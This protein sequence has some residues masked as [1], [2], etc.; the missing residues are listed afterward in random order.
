MG[1]LLPF[2]DGNTRFVSGIRQEIFARGSIAP[3]LPA[4]QYS[5]ATR[6]GVGE[7]S[8]ESPVLRKNSMRAENSAIPCGDGCPIQVIPSPSSAENLSRRNARGVYLYI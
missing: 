3:R 8:A 1:F 6:Y 7:P 4:K 2:S 5:D